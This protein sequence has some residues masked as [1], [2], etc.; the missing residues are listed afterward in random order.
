M[1]ERANK[2]AAKANAAIYNS[3]AMRKYVEGAPPIKHIALKNL[4]QKL[5][6]NVYAD[7]AKYTFCPRVLDL[8]AGEGS[9]TRNFLEA[10]ARVTAVD[11]SERQLKILNSKC[12]EY[13]DKLG[14]CCGEVSDII[15]KFRLEGKQYDIILANAFLHHIPD[16]LGLDPSCSSDSVALR[17]IFFIPG[18]FKVRYDSLGCFTRGFTNFVYFSWRIFQGDLIGGLKRRI[19]RSRG[20]Y[21]EN[22]P[23]D[24]F[25][26]HV[27]RGVDQNAIFGLFKE[28]G[29]KC[30]II[31]YFS[32]Q[33]RFW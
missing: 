29:F 1:D 13:K 31:R 17:P 5:A 21:L 18:S 25:E 9:V 15:G 32:T 28:L 16:Y 22:C 2:I 33:S 23:Q 6:L 8:G 12:A 27:N 19:R 26:Y 24:N 14:V 4:Y 7:A 20:I 11:I 3:E 10:G 30:E